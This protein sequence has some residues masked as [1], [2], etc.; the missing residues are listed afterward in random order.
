MPP[1]A[2]LSKQWAKLPQ[3]VRQNIDDY[4][5]WTPTPSA[6]AFNQAFQVYDGGWLVTD[7]A[8]LGNLRRCDCR[9]CVI[10]RGVGPELMQRF[11]TWSINMRT[12]RVYADHVHNGYTKCSAARQTTEPP[13][14]FWGYN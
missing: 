7:N 2:V 11:I 5:A 6:A 3:G 9:F 10:N 12:L 4:A 14:G 8:I 1:V 13:R